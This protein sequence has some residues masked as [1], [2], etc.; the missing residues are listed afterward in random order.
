MTIEQS[1]IEDLA[2]SPL[3][4]RTDEGMVQERPVDDMVKAAAAGQQAAMAAQNTGHNGVPVPWGMRIAR[5]T[6]G[7]P[8]N[9]VPPVG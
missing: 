4:V 3:K 2:A 9:N 1:D 5:A 6:P 8:N 7:N